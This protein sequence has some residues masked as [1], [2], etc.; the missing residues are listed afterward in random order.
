MVGQNRTGLSSEHHS[1]SVIDDVS[2][3]CTWPGAARVEGTEAPSGHRLPVERCLSAQQL[4]R[5]RRSAVALD[6]RT[7]ISS[8]TFYRMLQN[9]MPEANPIPFATLPWRPTVSLVL[10]VHRV[11]GLVEG[12][13]VLVR[14]LEQ[15]QSLRRSFRPDLMWKKPEGCPQSL[16]LYLLL[17]GDERAIART[18]SCGQDIAADG[19]FSAGMLVAFDEALSAAGPGMYSAFVLGNRRD[20]PSALSGSGGGSDPGHRHRLLLR[21][22]G[23][24]DPR[25]Q[26]PLLAEPLPLHHGRSCRGSAAPV[27]GCLWAFARRPDAVEDRLRIALL[28]TEQVVMGRSDRAEAYEF[29]V[30]PPTERTT[31]LSLPGVLSILGSPEMRSL[32]RSATGG[33]E[34]HP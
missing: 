13:Y 1:W 2:E 18:V 26:G 28:P 32:V 33:N 7:T 15:L 5:Q 6:G 23:S 3:A 24:S 21:R 27:L 9:V 11:S 16:P 19:V 31:L 10:F 25:D 34:E 17:T 30:L 22:R 20:W 12:L 8:G 4:I 29:R 14:H